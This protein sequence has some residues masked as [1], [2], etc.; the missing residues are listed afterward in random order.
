MLTLKNE[1]LTVEIAEL[2]AQ[3]RK[4]TL[5]G[6]DM[7][8]SGDPAYWAGVAP[9]MFP[10]C[11]G[12]LTEEYTCDGKTYAM[13][14]HGFARFYDFA[15]EDAG[16][17]FATFLLCAN[18]Q[19]KAQYPFDFEFRIG[20]RLAG[21]AVTITYDVRNVDTKMMPFAVGSHEGYATPEGI[22]AYDVVFPENETL[23]ACTLQGN[24]L[25]Y[26]TTTVLET[27]RCCR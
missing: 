1:R 2:G 22:E 16:D 15:V 18:E 5:D 20:Y 19:T 9:V 21:N 17:D 24:L 6:A 27:A 14:K 4:A 13:P 12:F 25:T 8:W 11:G 26:E 10:V 23:K 7:L 3:M